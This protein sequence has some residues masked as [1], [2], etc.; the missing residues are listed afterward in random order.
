MGGK[1]SSTSINKYMAKAYDRVALI[2][3]KGQK[4][5]WQA[6][7]EAEGVSLNKFIQEAVEAKIKEKR[8][9]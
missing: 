4:A 2:V 5:V 6:A 7:A 9:V 3:P 8:G 1:T